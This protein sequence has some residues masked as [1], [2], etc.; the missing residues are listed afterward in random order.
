MLAR[1]EGFRTPSLLIRSQVQ[2]VHRCPAQA[3]GCVAWPLSTDTN[4]SYLSLGDNR[5]RFLFGMPIVDN[6]TSLQPA[7]AGRPWLGISHHI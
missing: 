2:T 3:S 5:R 4:T 6:R 7:E 1:S